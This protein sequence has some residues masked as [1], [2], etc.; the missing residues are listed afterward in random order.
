METDSS[1]PSLAETLPRYVNRET[2]KFFKDKM[3]TSKQE[4]EKEDGGGDEKRR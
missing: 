3:R 2:L 1:P 4:K